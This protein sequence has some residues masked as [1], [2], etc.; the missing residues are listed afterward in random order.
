MRLTRC[1]SHCRYILILVMLISWLFML[2]SGTCAMPMPMQISAAKS[3][4]ALCSEAT[5]HQTT[6]FSPQLQDC[7]LKSCPDSQPNSSPNFKINK[8]QTP[9][10]VVCLIWLC[11]YFFYTSPSFAVSKLTRPPTAKPISLIYRFCTLL[12]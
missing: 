6:H 5:H 11:S 4:P 1:N 7:T 3:M 10:F 12:N 2:V 9:V 8:L